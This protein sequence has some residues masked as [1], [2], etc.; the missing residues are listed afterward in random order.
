MHNILTGMTMTSN[1]ALTLVCLLLAVFRIY[2]ELIGFNFLSLP[3]TKYLN[4]RN[5]FLATNVHKF[6]LIVSI[7]YIILFAPEL[8]FY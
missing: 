2:L 3:L 5:R 8:L 7:G 1:Q 4:E 6:G